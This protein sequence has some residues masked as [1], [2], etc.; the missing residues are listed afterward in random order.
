MELADEQRERIK[1]RDDL[2]KFVDLDGIVPIPATKGDGTGQDRLFDLLASS[3]GDG[4][5]SG[6]MSRLLANSDH[7]DANLESWLKD[8]F[9]TQHCKLFRYR[10]FIWPVWDGRR[11]GFPA[12]ANCH[13]FDRRMLESLAFAYLGDWIDRQIFGLPEGKEGA[14]GRLDAAVSLQTRLKE[15]HLGEPP[16]DI[17]V[18][19]KP[20]AEQPAGWNP[21]INDGVR[22]N[23]RPFMMPPDAGKKGSGFYW[24]I[25]TLTGTGTGVRT[26][27][28]PPGIA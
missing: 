9:C 20:L 28:P 12:L 15:I 24:T 22:L 8:K 23:V 25:Q 7:A 1:R 27:N 2:F 26:R 11:D 4:W 17:F 19:R 14:Q 21:D 18:R 3:H 10:P 6:V 5:S 13:K 16:Y